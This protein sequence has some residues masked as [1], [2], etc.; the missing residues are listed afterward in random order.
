V[1]EGLHPVPATDAALTRL[2]EAPGGVE[3]AP[4]A[5]APPATRPATVSTSIYRSGGGEFRPSE[6]RSARTDS[7]AAAPLSVAALLDSATLALPD[8]A[9]FGLH[10]YRVRFTPDYVSRPTI[11]YERDNFGRGVFGG[12][13]IV[14][15][16]ILGNQSLIFSGAVNGRISEAQVLAAYVNS[17]HRWSY[18]LGFQ[19]QPL[20]YYG[21]SSYSQGTGPGGT[22][23]LTEQVQRLVFRQAF[24]DTY[25]PIN[26]F[27]RIELGVRYTNVSQA[28]LNLQ[29]AIDPA[30]GAAIG[31]SDS[32]VAGRSLNLVQPS[33]ALVYDN[34][35]FGYTSPF[36]GRRYRFAVSPVF[37]DWR[38]TELLADYRRYDLIK[39]PFTVAT[40]ILALDRMGRDGDQFPVFLGSTDL[41]RGY[42]FG[43]YDA[44]MCT[45]SRAGIPSTTGCPELDQLIGSGIAVFSAELRFQLVRNLTLGFL[46]VGF[47]PIEGAL[48][49]DAGVAWNSNSTVR[50]SRPASADPNA[51]RVPLTSYGVGLRVNVL[52]IAIIRV[53][54]AVPNQRPGHGGYWMLSLGPPF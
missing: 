29:T 42:T 36:F 50:W 26:R 21:S 4:A 24:L 6:T 45:A 17:G 18:D 22:D 46:P 28:T 52:G 8:T 54:Y 5:G 3:A 34:S 37:G 31:Y 10:T 13:S 16:D 51:V 53:D 47:P 43:S 23:V 14:L 25:Y 12:T 44:S 11:G 15:S 32:T 41:V 1:A 19:Q 20:F 9:S 40:R 48:W 38:Y 27:R 30:S 35:L 39:Y 2:A 33:V 7:A 49:Y